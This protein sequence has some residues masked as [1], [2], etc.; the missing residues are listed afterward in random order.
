MSALHLR[1]AAA[2]AALAVLAPAATARAAP[3]GATAVATYGQAEVWL[4]PKDGDRLHRV[5]AYQAT[6]SSEPKVLDD[7]FRARYPWSKYRGTPDAVALGRDAQGR[8]TALAVGRSATYATTVT[9]TPRLRRVP[10]TT[11][12]DS[13]P[14]LWRGR[15]A[16]T[17]RV[18]DISSVQL[19]T[20]TSARTRRIAVD[21]EP[22]HAFTSVAVARGGAVA[23]TTYIEG[24]APKYLADLAVPGR[25]VKRLL[26]PVRSE[27]TLVGA[28]ADGRRVRLGTGE[29]ETRTFGVPR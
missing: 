17:R 6:P 11:A 19:G 9:R 16:F 14:S 3:D 20:L 29:D 25:R 5:L 8:L 26:G 24:N 13:H 10:A 18:G 1:A 27:L 7:D 12:R 28:S 23:Y 2:V 4:Q 22:A 15:L 21:R